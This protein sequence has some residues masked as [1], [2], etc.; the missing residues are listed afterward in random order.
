[1][2]DRTTMDYRETH[3]AKGGT[4]DATI[5]AIAY[6]V[7]FKAAASERSVTALSRMASATCILPT[8]LCCSCASA[9]H[10]VVS[11]QSFHRA[12]S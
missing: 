11:I 2:M 12:M 5:S 1:M 7:K 4:Y 9:H 3:Q 10:C 6:I 8:G